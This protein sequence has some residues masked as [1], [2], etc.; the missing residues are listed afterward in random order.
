MRDHSISL[1]Q[2]PSI[3]VR[4]HSEESSDEIVQRTISFGGSRRHCSRRQRMRRRPLT[5]FLPAS[6]ARCI[7]EFTTLTPA[8]IATPTILAPL[9]LPRSATRHQA[10]VDPTHSMDR[11]RRLSMTSITR[12]FYRW[13][14]NRA[15]GVPEGAALATIPILCPTATA[16]PRSRPAANLPWSEAIPAASRTSASKLTG[17]VHRAPLGAG[18]GS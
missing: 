8:M 18:K 14:P 17:L 7:I 12:Q 13:A 9:T 15:S 3:P 4:G 2:P 6:Q 11:T 1:L 16:P 10:T 5:P